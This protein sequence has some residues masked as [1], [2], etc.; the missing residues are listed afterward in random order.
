M[1]YAYPAIFRVDKDD[2]KYINVSFP[3][4]MGMVTCGEGMDDALFMAKDLLTLA[5]GID[6]LRDTPPTSLE[7]T[8]ANFPDAEIIMV[9]VDVDD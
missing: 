3:D 4:L 1:K 5:M 7:A 9:E 8:C 6:Y 2:N